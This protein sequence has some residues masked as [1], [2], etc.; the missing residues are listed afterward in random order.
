M[1]S[2][3]ARPPPMVTVRSTAKLL[4]PGNFQ[5]PEGAKHDT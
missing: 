5:F 4:Y 2:A 1:V 3:D